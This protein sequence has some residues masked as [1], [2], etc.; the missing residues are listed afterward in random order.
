MPLF[1]KQSDIDD[2]HKVIQQQQ[3]T[4]SQLQSDMDATQAQLSDYASFYMKYGGRDVFNAQKIV[5]KLTERKTKLEKQV[6][7][8]STT[9]QGL[10]AEEI[11]TDFSVYDLDEIANT[12]LTLQLESQKINAK[13]K[14]ALKAGKAEQHRTEALVGAEP[15]SKKSL[16]SIE[17]NISKLAMQAFNTEAKTLLEKVTPTN[18]AATVDRLGKQAKSVEKLAEIIELRIKD[19]Y[20]R[21]WAEAMKVEVELQKARSV[22][23]ELERENKAALREAAK[24]EREL[25][26]ERAKLEKEK[27]H[28]LNVVTSLEAAGDTA[29]VE[30][31][32]SKIAD[33]D[34]AIADVDYRHAN[35]R[36]GYVYVISN[37][38]S[39]GERMVKIGMTRRL[40]PEDRIRELSDASV[41]FNFDIHALFFSEDAVKLETDLHHIFADRRVNLVNA[42]REFFAVSPAEVKEE[43]MKINGSLIEFVDTPDAE[44]YRESLALRESRQHKAASAPS[45]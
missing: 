44:Q 41:P 34:K 10:Q 27:Q 9:L 7:S 39:F 42:R 6:E 20:I 4:I 35:Q 23:K 13:I 31:L 12:A 2:Y 21:M 8:L 33:V 5:D 1:V 24:V 25:E 29:Q 15:E 37:I 16:R 36:A 30:E 14:D 38:G 26:A 3:Y 17:K 32:R 18:Y 22:Q 45:D 43:L 40:K 28:Y 11:D 19:S